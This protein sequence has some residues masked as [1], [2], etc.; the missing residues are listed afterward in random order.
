MYSASQVDNATTSCFFEL[1][2]MVTF[3]NLKMYPKMFFLSFLSPHQSTS[4][5][6]CIHLLIALPH[7][8]ITHQNLGSL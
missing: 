2:L 3:L 5:K 1:Q 4:V 7:L 8:E 6:P